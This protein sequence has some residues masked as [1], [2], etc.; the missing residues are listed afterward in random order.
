MHF[1]NSLNWSFLVI[2]SSFAL[3]LIP[4]YKIRTER[5]GA[6]NLFLANFFSKVIFLKCFNPLFWYSESRNGAIFTVGLTTGALELFEMVFFPRFCTFYATSGFIPT[7]LR[8]LP[9]IVDNIVRSFSVRVT[10]NT[11]IYLLVKTFSYYAHHK[12]RNLGMY[13]L[14]AIKDSLITN[15][16]LFIYLIL[17]N[18]IYFCFIYNTSLTN[19]SYLQSIEEGSTSINRFYYHQISD[20][21]REPRARNRIL[22]S[23]SIV[24]YLRAYFK[25]EAKR[26]LEI[27]DKIE[28]TFK[29]VEAKKFY[30]VP[31]ILYSKENI[32]PQ[33]VS[34]G[35]QKQV[36]RKIR[37]YNF[38]EIWTAKVLAFFKR[39]KLLN[40]LHV[41]IF[42]LNDMALYVEKMKKHD[43][44]FGQFEN[45]FQDFREDLS[46][47][48]QKSREV[49]LKMKKK[50]SSY[51]LTSPIEKARNSEI[52]V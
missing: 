52:F 41:H 14:F 38:V 23:K 25:S 3:F 43:E 29:V 22:K 17:T 11:G 32:P 50:I 36:S 5:I 51:D 7:A 8:Q 15:A 40:E 24:A 48:R 34:E 33:L 49:E 10:M 21:S 26:I 42:W 27:L 31:V 30:V 35:H 44:V 19:R 12:S 18:V 47:I 1:R 4:E 37:S 2:L 39:K 45:F 28:F 20:S 6:C 16:C 13:L 9:K 46:L